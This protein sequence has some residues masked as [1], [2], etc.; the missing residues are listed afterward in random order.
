MF[1]LKPLWLLVRASTFLALFYSANVSAD[2]AL[3]IHGFD[4]HAITWQQSGIN[5]Y[6]HQQGWKYQGTLNDA[7]HTVVLQASGLVAPVAS[8]EH[9]GNKLYTVNLASRAPIAY[10][11]QQLSKMLYWLNQTHP[12][13]AIYLI[14]HSNGGLIARHALVQ[15]Y[16]LQPHTQY[17]NQITALI[18]IATP[19]LGTIRA[20]QAID[21]IDEPFFF[22]APGW[23]FL[24]EVFAGDDYHV[25][26]QSK[27]LLYELYPGQPGSLIF[28]LNR[29][30]HPEIYYYSIVRSSAFY[31]GDMLV[32]GYSQDMNNIPALQNRTLTLITP[33]EHF[34]T[35]HDALT[36]HSILGT[37]ATNNLNQP[38]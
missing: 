12:A 38:Q 19:H 10:Q 8:L 32:P 27:R 5:Q 14:G 18:T 17:P 26:K 36:I 23:R 28:S 30:P 20:A 1:I 2:I 15:L 4:S 35:H 11:S 6:L 16:Q 9:E 21:A 31:P 7:G 3:L 22:P 24:Q 33:T 29:Q 25:I 13:E 34:L 37:L